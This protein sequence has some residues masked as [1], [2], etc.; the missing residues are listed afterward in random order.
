[1]G[2]IAVPTWENLVTAAS[3]RGGIGLQTATANALYPVANVGDGDSQSLFAPAAVLDDWSVKIDN[4]LVNENMTATFLGGGATTYP[5]SFNAAEI[6]GTGSVTRHA[7][8]GLSAGPAMRLYAGVSG[9]A[10]AIL[11]RNLVAGRRYRVAAAAK[12]DAAGVNSLRVSIYN[13]V[14]GNVH[15]WNTGAWGDAGTNPML[16]DNNGGAITADNLVYDF[17]VE[18]Y[19][20]VG[21]KTVEVEVRFWVSGGSSELADLDDVKLLMMPNFT[22]VHGLHRLPRGYDVYL[23][24]GSA[25]GPALPLV[26]LYSETS[27]DPVV[28]RRSR[29][30][31]ERGSVW[32]SWSTL[33]SL[34]HYYL[35]FFKTGY[36]YGTTG[37]TA[38]M[39]SVAEWFLGQADQLSLELVHTE[40]ESH[41][42]RRELV[43]SR[44]QSVSGRQFVQNIGSRPRISRPL[45]YQV[46]GKDEDFDALSEIWEKTDY[47]ATT[48][49]V[50]PSTS[51]EEVL[52][53]RVSNIR[54][55]ERMTG[56]DG[57]EMAM[58]VGTMDLQEE[59]FTPV[60]S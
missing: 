60:S 6:S 28:Q 46:F 44:V 34:S 8:A 29:S 51:D 41:K 10:H 53:C 31:R 32:A 5:V 25:S 39:F 36:G 9:T 49:Q 58:H 22:A 1:M 54:E 14:T 19:E 35:R 2:M 48:L 15:N 57:S 56:S 50:V 20:Q 38:D 13:R 7:T 47:G 33:S 4:P 27:A 42:T 37:L 16:F 23:Y 3:A 21:G 59:P 30:L 45:P 52:L 17:T 26:T 11:R 12:Y 18:P 24:A 40:R 55:T 43:Q